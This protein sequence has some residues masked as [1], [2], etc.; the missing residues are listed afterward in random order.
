MDTEKIRNLLKMAKLQ[1][2]LK[3][4][5]VFID[6]AL[7]LLAL[8]PPT[9]PTVAKSPAEPA[10]DEPIR[11]DM[12]FQE[13]KCGTCGGTGSIWIT[14]NHDTEPDESAPCPDCTGQGEEEFVAKC[15]DELKKAHND[16][17]IFGLLLPQTLDLIN[18]LTAE[19]KEQAKH[20]KLLQ[21]CD[22]TSTNTISE[23]GIEIDHLTAENKKLADGI[24]TVNAACV[25]KT[26][27]LQADL[28][29]ANRRV[30]L[31]QMEI[32]KRDK[33]MEKKDEPKKD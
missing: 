29:T 20:I 33:A 17:C 28:A 6:Q 4:A 22:E 8:K 16:I 7:A 31:Q 19:N 9:M 5:K 13:P 26:R 32:E 23:I 30:A 18:R 11:L 24:E 15:R 21:Q 12:G 10:I 27:K 1:V 2:S 3:T 14:R 25:K